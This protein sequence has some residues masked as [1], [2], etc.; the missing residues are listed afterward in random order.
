MTKNINQRCIPVKGSIQAR[1]IYGRPDIPPEIQESYQASSAPD[2]AV[3]KGGTP[4]PLKQY[5]SE[6]RI[7]QSAFF[8]YSEQLVKR[9]IYGIK[10]IYALRSLWLR[11]PGALD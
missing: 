10:M 4:S 9:K 5:K 11:Q 1:K 2:G 3:G 7:C 6:K 8:L